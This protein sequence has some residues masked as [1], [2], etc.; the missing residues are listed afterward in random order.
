MKTFST[1]KKNL[2][3]IKEKAIKSKVIV[4][5]SFARAGEKGLG[6]ADMTK[7]R[8]DLRKIN[9]ELLV[10]KK[11]VTQRAMKNAKINIKTEDLEG[12]IGTIIGYED[13][14]LVFKALYDFSKKNPSLLYLSGIM[15]GNILSRDDI[16]KLAKLPSRDVLLGQI[17]G[18]MTYPIRSFMVVVDQLSK[19]S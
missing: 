19:K 14:M 8:R 17:V 12:S 3:K 18:M 7:L 6:V 9:S 4:F 16:T 1:K 13:P 2:D 11:T 10:D 15:D 5:A